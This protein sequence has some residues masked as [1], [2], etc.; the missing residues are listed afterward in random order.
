[1]IMSMLTLASRARWLILLT[2]L[3]LVGCSTAPVQKGEPIEPIFAAERVLSEDVPAI[4]EDISDPFEGLNRT[5]YRFNYHLDHKLL[6]P[7]IGVYEFVIPELLRKGVSNVF[8]N[9]FDITSF[10][11]SV[12]QLSAKKSATMLGR[13]VVNST[14]GVAGLWDP[15][16]RMGLNR[17]EEDFGQTLGHYGVGNGPFLVLPLLGPSNLRDGVGRLVDS[18]VFSTLILEPLDINDHVERAAPYYSLLILDTRSKVKFRY[19]ETGSPFEYDLVRFL[20]TTKRQLD[21]KR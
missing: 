15:A 10:I 6:F 8:D 2:A 18:I 7:L 13:V 16:T 14:I 5:I 19:F 11:N 21:I 20:Y 12:L 17:Y 4:D 1:M 3:V 9:L